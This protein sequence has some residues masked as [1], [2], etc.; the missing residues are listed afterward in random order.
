[1]AQERA[2]ADALVANDMSAFDA[3]MYPHFRLI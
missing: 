2:W 3:I 1:M